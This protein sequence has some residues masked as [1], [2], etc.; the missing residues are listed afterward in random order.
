MA[1]SAYAREVSFSY[2]ILNPVKAAAPL[3]K[4]IEIRIRDSLVSENAA[5]LYSH[6]PVK[7]QTFI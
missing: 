1:D 2:F 5:P 7:L 6:F 4:L 3:E